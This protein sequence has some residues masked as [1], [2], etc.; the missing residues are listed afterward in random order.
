ML[1]LRSGHVKERWKRHEYGPNSNVVLYSSVE[2]RRTKTF[3][4]HIKF[5]DAPPFSYLFFLGIIS[6]ELVIGISR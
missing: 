4:Y 2:E 3:S 6:C 5:I 1:D